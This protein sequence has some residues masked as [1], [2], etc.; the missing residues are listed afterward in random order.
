MTHE[1]SEVELWTARALFE[2][3]FEHAPVGMAV[4]RPLGGG[5]SEVLRCNETY[6][7][8]LGY[9]QEEL[10][11]RIST[12][13]MHPDDAEVRNRMLADLQAGRPATGELRVQHRDGHY[14]WVL[15]APALVTTPTGETLFVMHAVDITDRKRFESRLQHHA[16][17]DALTGLFSRRRF[18]QELRREVA[19]AKRAR[20][21]SSLLLV[22][23]D[24]F[25]YVNDSLGHS[26]GDALLV[27][28]AGALQGALR[29]VDVLARLG[30]DEFAV[31][32][33]DTEL[34]AGRLVAA[35]LLERVRQMDASASIGITALTGAR[36]QDAEGLLA[37][38]D[39]AM[40]QAKKAGRNQLAVFSKSWREAL[41]RR[42]D[43]VTRV[44]N[45]LAGE[46]LVAVA[47]PVVPLQPG[48][49]AIECYELLLRL[50]DGEG[51]LTAAGEFLPF[52]EREGLIV[53]V[54]RWMM[55]HAVEALHEA[56]TAGRRLSLA[57]NFSGVTVQD[58]HIAGELAQLLDRAP[59]G[60]NELIIEVTE[61]AAITNVARA[62][63]LARQVRTLGC[64]LALDDFGAG[65]ASFAYLKSLV[66]DILKID[67]SFIEELTGSPADQ[68]VVR[69]MVD[70]AHGFGASVVAERVGDQATVELLAALGVEFGQGY[71]LGRPAP[72]PAG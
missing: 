36:S 71:F 17:H 25:K 6:A 33:P 18:E 49:Q 56:H 70:V 31:I 27:Q 26:A 52:V 32:L 67:G 39:I 19:R 45:A 38:A 22:D 48:H 40:Y 10:V 24:G 13:L 1:A 43:W 58:P 30:G 69:A 41:T 4:T 37:E 9:P 46:G 5:L 35:K 57:V 55:S 50:P 64:K 72:L 54:D 3:A 29:E 34:E 16:D 53:D 14:L 47:Q 15:L 12:E 42:A 68:L 21:R 62:R 44:R 20:V 65:F 2:E 63:E 28:I 11:G 23:L 7:Q 8:M 60:S 61:T 59:I 66:F 51:G